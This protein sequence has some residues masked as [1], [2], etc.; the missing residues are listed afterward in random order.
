[1][2]IVSEVLEET[3]KRHGRLTPQIVLDEATPEDAP[4]HARFEWDDQ[5]AGHGYRLDQA[6]SLIRT[7]KLRV[8]ADEVYDVRK[9]VSIPAKADDPLAARSYVAA[10]EMT[11]SEREF[12]LRQMKIDWRILRRRW[13]RYDEFWGLVTTEANS[14]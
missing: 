5:K 1:M 2:I 11:P 12:A 10:D 14:A 13:S 3:Y 4:L 9:Y 6:R 8:I 7:V